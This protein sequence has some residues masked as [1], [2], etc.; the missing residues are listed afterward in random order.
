MEKQELT[1][2]IVATVLTTVT[3]ILGLALA[4]FLLATTQALSPLIRWLM[5]ACCIALAFAIIGLL[6]SKIAEIR[7]LRLCVRDR[8]TPDAPIKRVRG[9]KVA[10][11]AKQAAK[12]KPVKEAKPSKEA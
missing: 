12:E 2:K 7:A 3:L 4:I 10:R 9:V 1:R 11:P 5:L 8:V 6:R